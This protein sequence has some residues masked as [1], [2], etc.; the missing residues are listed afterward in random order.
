MEQILKTTVLTQWRDRADTSDGCWLSF[1]LKLNRFW[2]DKNSLLLSNAKSAMIRHQLPLSKQVIL[3]L[4]GAT[5][6]MHF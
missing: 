6:N 5:L 3:I 1:R 4:G 2:V